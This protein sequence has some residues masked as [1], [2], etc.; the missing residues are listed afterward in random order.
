MY[1]TI[2]GKLV[3]FSSFIIVFLSLLVVA[4][5][6]LRIK[7][8]S[9]EQ[10]RTNMERETAL[11]ESSINIF[12]AGTKS[13][14]EMLASHPD[15]RLINDEINSYVDRPE[16]TDLKTVE[17]TA[18]ERRIYDLLRSTFVSH[19]D[20]VEVFLG[21]KWGGKVTSFDGMQTANYDPRKRAWYKAAT[22]KAGTTVVAK[23]YQS[24]L[25]IDGMLP[26]V[27]C[28]TRSIMSP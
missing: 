25:K 2:R 10:F 28:I 3:I 15:I 8:S 1:F 21:T 6:G 17:R 18:L 26:V 27:V 24:T 22:E 14:V 13:N 7:K 23:A 5:V 11:V 4:V 20:Y 19:N 12:L 9:E 16:L